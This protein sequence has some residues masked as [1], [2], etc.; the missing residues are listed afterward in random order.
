MLSTKFVRHIDDLGRIAFPVANL[1]SINLHKGDPV[2][3]SIQKDGTIII[4][5]YKKSWEDTVLEWW[6]ANR[7]MALRYAA[8]SRVNDY[9]FCVVTRPNDCS[10]GGYAKRFFKD[11]DDYRIAQVAAYAKAIHV[12]IDKLVGWKG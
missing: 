4:R 3:I 7:N 1:N 2:E 9:T 12:P 8:F 10:R 5:P 11:K 6:E